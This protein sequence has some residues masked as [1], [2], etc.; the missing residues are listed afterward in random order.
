MKN[1]APKA[2]LL[3]LAI[4][5]PLCAIAADRPNFMILMLDDAGWSDLGCYGGVP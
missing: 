3:L 2:L 5:T 4:L 1:K